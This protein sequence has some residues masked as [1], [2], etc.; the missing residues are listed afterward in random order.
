[1]PMAIPRFNR[2]KQNQYSTT[3]ATRPMT[4]GRGA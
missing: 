4:A 2:K 1:L 3:E